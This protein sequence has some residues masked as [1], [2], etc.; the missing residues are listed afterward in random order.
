[1]LD[2]LSRPALTGLVRQSVR[3]ESGLFI[4]VLAIYMVVTAVNLHSSLH[5]DVAAPPGQAE[6]FAKNLGDLIPGDV[7]H[8]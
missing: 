1:M 5:P 8:R 6:Y 7:I 3:W 2:S 4:L